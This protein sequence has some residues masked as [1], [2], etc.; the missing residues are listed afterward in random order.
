MHFVYWYIIFG[1]VNTFGTVLIP[2]LSYPDSC[3]VFRLTPNGPIVVA[4][5][6][7]TVELH[8]NYPSIMY[9][10]NKNTNNNKVDIKK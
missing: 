3:I 5:R 10:F 4:E 1:F 7:L 8:I 6:F 9:T 2:R